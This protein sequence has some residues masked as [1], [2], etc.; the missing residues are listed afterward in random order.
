[1]EGL[2]APRAPGCGRG[3]AE[4][5]HS[6]TYFTSHGCNVT[7]ASPAG[8]A[9]APDPQGFVFYANDPLTQA[10]VAKR[11]DGSPYVPATEATVAVASV[12]DQDLE[13]YDIVFFVGGTGAMWD[14]INNTDIGRIVRRMWEG[15][16]VVSAVCHGPMALVQATLSDGSRFLDG[17]VLTGF[18]NAEE[19]VLGPVNVCVF[20][21]PGNEAAGCPV[22]FSPANCTGP[23][24]P[25]EYYA[26]GS[27]LLEDGIK[28]AGAVYVST[29]QNW[30]T[31]YYRPHVVRHGRLVTG[32]NPGAGWE[33]A[34]A[35]F[36]AHRLLGRRG[37]PVS[38]QFADV[39]CSPIQQTATD[40]PV[41][42]KTTGYIPSC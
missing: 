39:F 2:M 32:Q 41:K 7:V 1:M 36:D 19:E 20:C 10:L 11:P 34:E 40:P 8:G 30:K 3:L 38:S 17:K 15:D 22:G 5:T 13:E 33:T 14:F 4:F 29:E 31:F 21:F 18:S 9:G 42:C 23:H 27:F 26:Q 28:G 16:K 12:S 6:Y 35:A 37:C 25:T 24:M